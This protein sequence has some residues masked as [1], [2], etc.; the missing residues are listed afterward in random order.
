[1]LNANKLAVLGLLVSDAIERALGAFSPSAA[2]LLLTL[3]DRGSM[4]ASALAPILGVAQPTAVR[5][6]GGLAPQG[7]L[8]AAH[9]GGRAPERY[10]TQLFLAAVGDGQQA[11]AAREDR[12]PGGRRQVGEDPVPEAPPTTRRGSQD[13]ARVGGRVGVRLQGSGYR[14]LA[15]NRRDC[16]FDLLGQCAREGSGARVRGG[17]RPAP[18]AAARARACSRL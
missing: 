12:H 5:V 2:A 13:L 8:R 9:G 16:R 6:A 11:Q 1:M 17:A 4:T 3:H 7:P 18:G 10:C 15:L 14:L